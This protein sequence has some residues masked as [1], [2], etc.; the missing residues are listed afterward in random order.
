M[1]KI[2]GS[3]KE[4]ILRMVQFRVESLLYLTVIWS[5]SLAVADDWPQYQGPNRNGLSQ[6]TGLAKSWPSGGPKV[7]WSVPLGKGFGGPAIRD[8]EVYVLDRVKGRQDVLR[9]YSL[10]SGDE[11]WN[12]AYKSVGRTSYTG[13]RTTPA[14]TER[15]VYSVGL[16]GEFYCFDC[17][18]HEPVWH[19][20]LRR[21]FHYKN[22]PLWGFAQAPILYNDLVVI[23]P[24]AR[25]AMVAAFNRHDGSLVW[26]SPGTKGGGYV[27]PLPV[28]LDGVDQVVMVVPDEGGE[29]DLVAGV[30]LADGRILWRYSDW[31]C[32]IPIAPP[33]K[34]PGDRILITGGYNAGSV[35]LEIKKN[36]SEFVVSEVFSTKGFGCQIQQ[37]L[38]MHD[39]IYGISNENKRK[40]GL[41]RMGLDGKVHWKMSDTKGEPALGHGG[42]LGFPK[43]NLIVTLDGGKGSLHLIEV[44]PDARY[45]ELARTQIFEGKQM[46][47]P[48][49][50]SN[51]K[52][53]LRSQEELK[54]LDLVNP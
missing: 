1:I 32:R 20:S 33:T 14:V 38:L 34:L 13:S 37:P 11:L 43:E 7:L 26:K 5:C 4:G 17:K 42:L 2:C 25:D 46:W 52:L 18:T 41:V 15:Y 21:E 28:R 23:A 24:Q 49:A 10:E 19:H 22:F 53:V 39:L 16:M 12:F 40:D 9:C 47:S 30:S 29:P 27:T 51:G 48:M 35:A 6:E 44:K 36:G 8:G 45:K 50:F 54:C 31:H 3:R